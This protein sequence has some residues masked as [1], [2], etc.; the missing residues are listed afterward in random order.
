MEKCIEEVKKL[1]YPVQIL[2][3]SPS[4]LSTDCL[5]PLGDIEFGKTS[6]LLSILNA[7]NEVAQF[8]HDCISSKKINKKL[9]INKNVNRKLN[10][11][12]ELIAC[13]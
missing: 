8:M 6:Y 4:P 12:C 11:E 5:K 3:V 7:F 1:P 10:S 2:L 13:I 9:N